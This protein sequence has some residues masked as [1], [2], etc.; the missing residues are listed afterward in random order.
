LHL[1]RDVAQ[2]AEEWRTAWRWFGAGAGCGVLVGA[3]SGQVACQTKTL[4]VQHR[5]PR[6][7]RQAVLEARE[8]MQRLY[9]DEPYQF[10]RPVENPLWPRIL[11]PFLPRHLRNAWGIE[12]WEVRGLDQLQASTNAGDGVLLVS[13]HTRP[14]DPALLGTIQYLTRRPSYYMAGWHVFKQSWWQT[15]LARRCGAFSI[16]REGPD[17]QALEFTIDALVEARRPV[18]MFGEGG[19]SRANDLVQEMAEGV[20]FIARTAAKRRAR[21]GSGRVVIHPVA[22]KYLFRGD[23]HQAALPVLED[24]ER[25]LTWQT[26]EHLGLVQRIHKIGEAL[27]AIK[28]IE[29]LGCPQ[30]GTFPQ[31]RQ[32]L[33]ETILRPLE[34]EWVAGN[35]EGNVFAR[36][37]RL[38]AA[39]LPDMIERKVSPQERRRRWRQM[40]QI[41]LAQ[42]ISC[43]PPDY[44]RSRPTAERI[45]ETLD[46]YEEDITDHSRI[47]RPWHAIVWIGA[48]MPVEPQRVRGQTD[49]L[50]LD[51]RSRLQSMLDELALE[52][53]PVVD[54]PPPTAPANTPQVSAT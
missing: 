23:V 53:G 41:Y 19:I 52:S 27:L 17:K 20:A 3:R 13:N 26:Q 35:S 29:F 36:C 39:I 42:Q 43:Y 44:V 49:P 7:P 15:F 11:R 9:F 38:R 48:A 1:L 51:L 30:S 34:A 40:E 5:R 18:I 50:L 24:I 16:Y 28:E 31:R 33:I 10:V 14:S 54:A 4:G 46:R 45:L 47:H 6:G 22:L 2:A 32:R 21:S 37:R 8:P 12:T 25:R